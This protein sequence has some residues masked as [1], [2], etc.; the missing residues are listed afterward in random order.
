MD[1]MRSIINKHDGRIFSKLNNYNT[2]SKETSCN[3]RSKVSCPLQRYCLTTNLIYWAEI[4]TSDDTTTKKYIGISANTFKSRYN[5]HTKSFRG[6]RY[7][8]E[9][10]LSSYIRKLKMKKQDYS[11]KWSI[12]KRARLYKNGDKRCNLCLEEKMCFTK[13]DPNDLLDKRT[14]IF[15]KCRH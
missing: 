14:E 11:E 1:N 4:S 15:S 12:L 13:A 7:S 3:S 6:I 9:T 2:N 8:K 5:I 10:A